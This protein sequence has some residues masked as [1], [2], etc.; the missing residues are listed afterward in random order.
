MEILNDYG[1]FR[2]H[3]AAFKDVFMEKYLPEGE[4]FC[5]PLTKGLIYAP[6]SDDE[7]KSNDATICRLSDMMLMSE[8]GETDWM[9]FNITKAREIAEANEHIFLSDLLFKTSFVAQDWMI[10]GKHDQ[11]IVSEQYMKEHNKPY[12]PVTPLTNQKMKIKKIVNENFWKQGTLEAPVSISFEDLSASLDDF[13]AEK[14]EKF[15]LISGV[16][17]HTLTV[18]ETCAKVSAECAKMSVLNNSLSVISELKAKMDEAAPLLKAIG[19]GMTAVGYSI[20]FLVAVLNKNGIEIN[21]A[22]FRNKFYDAQV[23]KL[24]AEHTID[25][26][27]S[28]AKA[29]LIAAF[30]A[31]GKIPSDSTPAAE[32]YEKLRE[33]ETSPL[34]KDE[35]LAKA[36]ELLSVK[37]ADRAVFKLLYSNFSA[38]AD[39]ISEAEEFW[40]GSK[41]T[42]SDDELNIHLT[43]QYIPADAIGEKGDYI[44]GF[45]KAKLIYEELSAAAG[46]YHFADCPAAAN[47]KKYIDEEDKKSRTF[48]GTVFESAEEMAKAVKNE[49]ELA[50]LCTDLS[51]LNR[52]ELKKLK[53]YIFDSTADDKTKAKYIVKAKLAENSAEDSEL[54]QLTLS[55]PL[56]KL[57]EVKSLLEKL[58]AA[59]Y[60]DTVKKPYISAAEDRL[61]SAQADELSEKYKD[62]DKKSASEIDALVKETDSDRYCAMLKKH[63]LRRADAAKNALARKDLDALCAGMESLDKEKLAELRKKVEEKD[64]PSAVSARY[65]GRISALTAEC[66]R[67][68]VREVFGKISSAS[69]EELDRLRE[70]INSG[71][72]A[73]ELTDPYIDRIAERET[74]LRFEEFETRC[75]TI[76][77]MDKEALAAIKAEFTGGKYPAELTDKYSPDI[78]IRENDLEKQE[79]DDLCKDIPTM[80]RPELKKLAE[81][82]SDTKYNSEFTA[83]YFDKIKER[84]IAAEKEEIEELCRDIPTMKD[85]D[86]KKLSEALSDTKFNADH[87]APYF[88]KIKARKVEIEKA[89]LAELCKDIASMKRDDLKKL[90]EKLAD[91][92]YNKEYTAEY[93]AKIKDRNL[94]L[95]NIEVDEACRDITKM[96]RAALKALS[97]KISDE[98]YSK[99]YT[100]KYFD[101]IKAREADIDRAELTE[102]TKNVD[103]LKKSE[104]VKLTAD[105][106][107]KYSKEVSAPFIEKVRAKEISLMK[108]EMENL[109]RNIPSTPRPELSKLKEALKSDDFDKEL[110][111]K[112]ITQIEERE[113]ALIKTELQNLCKNIDTAPKDKLLEIKLKITDTPEYKEQGKQYIDRIDTRLK[114]LDKEEFDKMMTS[115]STMDL[116][117]LD[118]F[119]EELEKRKPTLEP[120]KYTEMLGLI[121]ARFDKLENDELNKLCGN[122]PELKIEQITSILNT[123]ED[124]G[125]KDKNA[126]SFIKKLNDAANQLYIKDLSKLTENL[127]GLNKAALLDVCKKI[128]D[129]GNGCPDDLKKRY[130]GIVRKKI[131]ELDD[132]RVEQVCRNLGSL[133]KNETLKIIA[134]IREMDIDEDAKKRHIST[135]EN[136]ILSSKKAER[137]SYT[138]KL[139]A[140]MVEASINQSHVI[141]GDS[142]TFDSTALKMQNSF[143]KMGQFDLPVLLH[144]VT[145]GNPDEGFI[146]TLEYVFCR[147]KNGLI[148]KK[149]VDDIDRFIG[150]K[151]LLGNGS[152]RLE[153]KNGTSTDLPIGIKGAAIEG[154]AVVLNKLLTY[155][156]S[157]RSEE[158]RKDLEANAARND[159]FMDLTADAPIP[160]AASKPA[161]APKPAEPTPAPKPAETPVQPAAKPAE[162]VQAAAPKPVEVPDVSVDIK[163]IK[164]IETTAPISKNADIKDIKPIKPITGE[165][166][167]PVEVPKAEAPKPVEVPKAEAPKPVEVPKAE[168]PK[169]V[170]VPKAEAPKSIEV[171]KAEAPKP[172]PQP[173][174]APSSAK[175]IKMKFCDQCGAKIMSE[176]AKFCSECGNKIAR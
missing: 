142:P 118:K 125:F 129:Y 137:D 48:N 29:A 2:E 122:I 46:K 31:N 22:E 7:A 75:K 43:K 170:E 167:K 26:E 69:K 136:H 140:D 9:P 145:Q 83:P 113:N 6:A 59:E 15:P 138:L 16:S 126:Q 72:Y 81:T 106:N 78:I 174:P 173:A 52:D 128:S 166:V 49:A 134:Q 165:E 19:M 133:T 99:D 45:P 58:N 8:D 102:L 115:V 76:P 100:A 10:D 32:Y 93:T 135:C 71:K 153:E 62:I 160:P 157:T 144:T 127:G 37:P 30:A 40:F 55:L 44:C 149:A 104:L 168:A 53:K 54:K 94:Q 130:D 124:K 171:P 39:D 175:P 143:A 24:P 156:Q 67:K 33:I 123:I 164:H 51:A 98:K 141:T 82:L 35:L 63:F 103:K 120:A 119:S 110:S 12:A 96:D 11:M 74:A 172:A 4:L 87:T 70:I 65:I 13:S 3:C 66:D 109:C 42:Y 36:V 108:A 155:V 27:L 64:Y 114:K 21:G 61:L 80:K 117:A 41:E 163:P 169:P 23:K 132:K 159:T 84:E 151:G 111:A 47:L 148:S 101:Q 34:T 88:D 68:E 152:L 14:L 38:N 92:K 50:K 154:A 85:E 77:T 79:I 112:Y 20:K 60:D 161:E 91:P 18:G 97:E 25:D 116:S 147:N 28:A 121:D 139:S 146:F 56:M 162:P 57:D 95:D 150:K 107:E 73:T 131:R 1:K 17:A 105:I 90:S 5:H 89:E 176:S 86:L 158:R